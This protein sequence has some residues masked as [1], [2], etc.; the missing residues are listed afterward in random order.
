MG[1]NICNSKMYASNQTFPN[2]QICKCVIVIYHRIK[3]STQGKQWATL[4]HVS[5]GRKSCVKCLNWWIHMVW[6]ICVSLKACQWYFTLL[7]DSHIC[8]RNINKCLRMMISN[9]DGLKLCGVG[10]GLNGPWKD[11]SVWVT[12]FLLIWVVDML[13]FI[14]CLSLLYV[15]NLSQPIS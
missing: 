2:K 15:W 8:G 11:S 6:E 5:I 14:F 7:S 10:G 9:L 3:Y 1:S 12:Y 4:A 13:M